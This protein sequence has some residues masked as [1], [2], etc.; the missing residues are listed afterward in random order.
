M[1]ELPANRPP[2]DCHSEANDLAQM[3]LRQSGL[4]QDAPLR[5]RLADKARE[6]WALR[7]FA[8]NF[9]INRRRYAR[10][11]HAL[12]P[13]YTIWT[14]TNACNFRCAYCD[15]HQGKHFYDVP[16][17]NRL[18]T[19]QSKRLLEVLITGT[20]ALYWCGGEPTLRADLPE[21]LEYACKLGFFPNMV[22]T[23]AS[24][25][26]DLLM[27]QTW[28]NFLLCTDV[29]IVSLDGLDPERLNSMW[30]TSRARQ[31]L[32][33]LLMLRRLQEH[34]RFKLVVNSVITRDNISDVRAILDFCCENGIW[35]V[36]AIVNWGHRPD[37]A[38]L[39]E[40]AYR[41]LVEV[42]LQRKNAGE[43]IVGSAMLLDRYLGA[44]SYEC[45]TS[46]KPHI[47][48]D[49]HLCWP[50]RASQNV[51]PV[52]IDLLDFETMD[53]AYRAARE[54]VSPDLF[55]GPG[56]DQCGGECVWMQNSVVARYRDALIRPLLRRRAKLTR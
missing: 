45:L 51:V 53:D 27:K 17:P 26:H 10:G 38:L 6:A 55:H 20:S 56:T 5:V 35:F 47:W 13:L 32:V 2:Q 1:Q 48:S 12:R 43:M 49:G 39:I 44:K 15:N 9:L 14:M 36:P 24:L 40:P 30:G 29:L 54:L 3:I 46:L 33:N 18:N 19:K 52:D 31:V 34:V 28:K 8:L 7:R 37:G 50:C 42:I 4:V 11:E 41:E 25:L 16:E 21:L 22:N 23:N